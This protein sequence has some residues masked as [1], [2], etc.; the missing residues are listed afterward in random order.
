[1]K[2]A[3]IDS[4]QM[5]NHNHS[6][7][8]KA[9][10]VAYQVPNA[11]PTKLK[12]K[13][14]YPPETVLA[15]KTEDIK[16]EWLKV[17]Q[18]AQSKPVPV[19]PPKRE[20]TKKKGILFSTHKNISEI[21]VTSALGKKIVREFATDDI[22]VL[23]HIVKTFIANNYSTEKAKTLEK[24]IFKLSVKTAMLYKGKHITPEQLLPTRTVV[25]KIWSCVIDYCE[26][27]WT[28]DITHLS[29]LLKNFQDQLIAVLKLH[30][31]PSSINRVKDT[32]QLLSSHET[33]EKFFSSQMELQQQQ[34][35]QILRKLWDFK[36][37]EDD[38]K[39]SQSDVVVFAPTGNYTDP[40]NF[41]A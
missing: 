39:I 2:D 36:L 15:A 9:P 29:N 16:Q 37:T 21:V 25:I 32:F 10:L 23:L 12:R 40:G 11:T 18:E 38:K 35:L 1:L 5:L 19:S 41:Q 28:T 7:T 20:T 22:L 31:T 33:L 14:D 27:A 13:K 8:I 6:F 24:N 30:L 26:M 4:K 3:K 34:T 17:L